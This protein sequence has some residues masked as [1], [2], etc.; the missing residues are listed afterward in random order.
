MIRFHFLTEKNYF[1]QAQKNRGGC[2]RLDACRIPSG[3]DNIRVNTGTVNDKSGSPF[4]GNNTKKGVQEWGTTGDRYAQD[5]A[6]KGRYCPN[7]LVSDEVLG[8]YSKYFDLDAWTQFLPIPKPSKAEKNL[9]ITSEEVEAF[10][11]N[12]PRKCTKCNRWEIDGKRASCECK[13]PNWERPKKRNVHPTVKPVALGAFLVALGS[14]RGDVV[15]DP[16]AG[17]GSFLVAAKIMGRNFIGVE[18]EK[19]YLPLIYD[20]LEASDQIAEYLKEKLPN[21]TY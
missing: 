8:S 20:R 19:D 1:S 6:H 2:T 4:A 3:D 13:H 18:M 17:S 16:F 5:T 12:V 11:T 7:L 15:L 10:S 14:D 9:G 21:E